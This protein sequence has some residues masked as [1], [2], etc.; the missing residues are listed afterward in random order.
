MVSILPF[1]GL[2]AKKICFLAFDP[3]CFPADESLQ[4]WIVDIH[5][6]IMLHGGD[7]A[8]FEVRFMAYRRGEPQVS[9]LTFQLKFC[10]DSSTTGIGTDSVL[11]FGLQSGRHASVRLPIRQTG[12]RLNRRHARKQLALTVGPVPGRAGIAATSYGSQYFHHP[13][14]WQRLRCQLLP[15]GYRR[16][17]VR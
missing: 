8:V 2:Q 12:L 11:I 10:A 4:Q 7:N 14:P 6:L 16:R 5:E 17:F 15:F 1:P 9:L 3:S 13:M